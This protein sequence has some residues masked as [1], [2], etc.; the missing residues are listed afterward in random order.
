MTKQE[1]TYA[2]MVT[3]DLHRDTP[4]LCRRGNQAWLQHSWDAFSKV[5]VRCGMAFPEPQ[6]KP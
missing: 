1:S 6:K 2:N 4:G 5:C 3:R